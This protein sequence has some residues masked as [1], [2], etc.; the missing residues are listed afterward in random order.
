MY[1]T[2]IDLVSEDKSRD[3]GHKLSQEHQ[4]QK[5]GILEGAIKGK[6]SKVTSEGNIS[7]NLL[8]LH[9]PV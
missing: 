5:H 7:V 6:L 4:G 2:V 8:R 9:P 3:T 1:L